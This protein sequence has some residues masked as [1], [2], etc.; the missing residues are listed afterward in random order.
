MNW[1]VWV[2]FPG[3]GRGHKFV[4][5]NKQNIWLL[6]KQTWIIWH[7]SVSLWVESTALNEFP[8]VG[9]RSRISIRKECVVLCR[10]NANFLAG[11]QMSGS[12]NGFSLPRTIAQLKL[13]GA[14]NDVAREQIVSVGPS[15]SSLA[16]SRS[17]LCVRAWELPPPGAGCELVVF[18]RFSW[19]TEK[20]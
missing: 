13:A 20:S 8:R 1:P 12:W 15:T 3:G 6:A 5:L 7:G 9:G 10:E 4:S 14:E 16:T 19:K 18:L 11:E 2:G 17:R